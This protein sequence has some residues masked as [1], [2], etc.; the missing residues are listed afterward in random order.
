M[1]K[2]RSRGSIPRFV[3]LRFWL[4]DS[5]AW[6]SLPCNARALYLQLAKRYNGSNNGRISYSVRQASQELNLGKH[7]TVRAFQALQNRGF[8]VCT[9][10]GAFSWKTVCEASEWRLT[11][12]DNNFPPQHASKE[13]MRWRPPEPES[14]EP[15]EF[16]TR[17][18]KRDRTGSETG[19][20]RFSGGTMSAKKGP[21]GFSGGTTNTEKD[22]SIGSETGH[23]HL[24]DASPETAK[25][26]RR[27]K[28]TLPT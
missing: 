6:R 27:P 17:V 19:P 10:K 7:A 3:W 5:P 8:I 26:D 14:N 24:P 2:R 15:P 23:L 16:R 13:F 20:H 11:E 28:T 22:P 9:K 18:R 4:M 25:I 21:Y 12:Y 1:N